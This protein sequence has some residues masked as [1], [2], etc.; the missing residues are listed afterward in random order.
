MLWTLNTLLEYEG[1]LAARTYTAADAFNKLQ[2]NNDKLNNAYI[3]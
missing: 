3:M 1:F 2:Y